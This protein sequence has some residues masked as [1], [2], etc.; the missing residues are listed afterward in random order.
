[1]T[2]AS[3]IIEN[4]RLYAQLPASKTDLFRQGVKLTITAAQDNAYALQSL[5]RLYTQFP[6]FLQTPFFDTDKGFG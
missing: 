4:N 2:Q 1:M 5:R 6:T 3:I